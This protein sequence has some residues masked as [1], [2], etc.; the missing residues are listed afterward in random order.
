MY[1]MA[2]A[3]ACTVHSQ[4]SDIN[5]ILR[6]SHLLSH[7]WQVQKYN[8]IIN[9][10]LLDIVPYL[11]IILYMHTYSLTFDLVMRRPEPKRISHHCTDL[12]IHIRSFYSS[13]T[14]ACAWYTAV[15]FSLIYLF[16]LFYFGGMRLLTTGDF[17]LWEIILLAFALRAKPVCAASGELL[18]VQK[19]AL[20]KLKQT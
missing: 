9:K 12:W 8:V 18:V 5:V 7:I 10:H 11:C 13:Y 14:P 16:I 15:L 2:T 19:V 17:S 1:N 6:S 4:T 3:E 20:T